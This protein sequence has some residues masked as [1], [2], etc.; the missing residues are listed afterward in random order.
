M[1]KGTAFLLVG[2]LDQSRTAHSAGLGAGMTCCTDVHHSVHLKD[3][4][5]SHN[6]RQHFRTRCAKSS[7]GAAHCLSMLVGG[8][9]PYPSLWPAQRMLVSCKVSAQW[10]DPSMPKRCRKAS[11]M[12]CQTL[13]DSCSR[14]IQPYHASSRYNGGPGMSAQQTI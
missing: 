13:H 12:Q 4:S 9:I 6:E 1:I 11:F 14:T 8:G 10:L 2:Q 5:A 3:L 7:K